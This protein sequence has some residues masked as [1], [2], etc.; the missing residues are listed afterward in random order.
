MIV[1]LNARFVKLT[2]LK[3]I[4][5]FMFVNRSP[6]YLLMDSN[7]FIEKPIGN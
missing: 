6:F 7:S 3:N 2:A 5:N 4:W 1:F